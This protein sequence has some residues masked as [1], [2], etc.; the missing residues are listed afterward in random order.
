MLLKSTLATPK[1]LRLKAIASQFKVKSTS[2]ESPTMICLLQT[3]TQAIQPDTTV[4]PG[5]MFK[6]VLF[7]K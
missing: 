4:G 5:Q 7:P 3:W 1:I 2:T 6:A